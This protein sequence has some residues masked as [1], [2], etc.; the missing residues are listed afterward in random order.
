MK[1]LLLALGFLA[2]LSVPAKSSMLDLSLGGD[3][4][5]N[6]STSLNDFALTG[7]WDCTNRVAIAGYEK[8]VVQTWRG[9]DEVAYLAAQHLFDAGHNGRGRF[10]L[11]LGVY[12]HSIGSVISGN[13]GRIKK[14]FPNIPG[15]LDKLDNFTSVEL[16]GGY[17]PTP[18]E[19]EKPWYWSV[20]G[21]LKIP[22][23]AFFALFSSAK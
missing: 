18:L 20:S 12:T 4:K 6:I 8:E 16:G 3:W 13:T 23:D 2:F 14:L 9:Q 22:T 7:G 5:V 19:Q 10:G 17:N 15:W 11:A 1:K 21:K